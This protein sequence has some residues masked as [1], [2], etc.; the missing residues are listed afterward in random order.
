MNI[1]QHNVLSRLP[2]AYR[3]MSESPRR[4]DIGHCGLP[5]LTAL[6]LLSIITYGG[7]HWSMIGHAINVT[8][9]TYS[10]QELQSVLDQFEGDDPAYHLWRRNSGGS[11][12]LL[13]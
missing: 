5:M 4:R 6:L 8:G 2:E 10:E 11:Y 9:F 7:C 1:T 12:E 13:I 3:L